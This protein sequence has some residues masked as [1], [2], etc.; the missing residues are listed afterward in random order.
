VK[1]AS[2][3]LSNKQQKHTYSIDQV[4]ILSFGVSRSAKEGK[5]KSGEAKYL[6]PANQSVSEY[7]THHL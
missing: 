5:E 6:Q 1:P 2:H 7:Q 4:I 3:L